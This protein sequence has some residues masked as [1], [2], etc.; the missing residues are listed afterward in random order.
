MFFLVPVIV[1]ATAFAEPEFGSVTICKGVSDERFY[2]VD[3]SDTFSTDTPVLHS[4]VTIKDAM[5]GTKV[6][7]VWIAV[8][9]ASVPANNQIESMDLE[10][11]EAGTSNAHFQLR[12]PEK[13]WPVGKYKFDVYLDGKLVGSASFK[14]Q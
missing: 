8:E 5:P 14:V 2:P 12:K 10:F 9:A 3:A 6:T 11:K 4:V 1:C 13:G 7:G